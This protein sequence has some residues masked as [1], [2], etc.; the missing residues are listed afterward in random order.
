MSS[1]SAYLLRRRKLGNGSTLGIVAASNTGIK[2]FR[3]DKPIPTDSNLLCIRWGCTSTVP[4]SMVLN[5]AAAI[6]EVSDKKK[7]RK[8]LGSL[9]PKTWF[10]ITEWSV[11]SYFPVVVRPALHAQGKHCYKCDSFS[12]LNKAI[13]KCGNDYYISVYVP[14]VAEYRVFV[15]S[16][17]AVWV[18][19]KTPADPSA[20]AWNVAQGGKFDN[21]RWAE[22][23]LRVVDHAIQSINKSSLDF[24]GV[25]IMVDA[26][27]NCYCLE[28]NA[29][30]SQTSPYR[31]QC[32]AKVFDYICTTSNKNAIPVGTKGKYR[33]YIHPALD[34]AAVLS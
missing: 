30:P 29:A 5:N 28:I 7:F 3:N 32:V 19:S 4:Q 18:A 17:R 8:T 26:E 12:E 23:P 16:G 6:H 25:D 33:K 13:T 14:K 9:A 15:A 2:V 21:V 31:Q 20:V 22:W 27:G 34:P 11:D 1:F 24:G 10:S